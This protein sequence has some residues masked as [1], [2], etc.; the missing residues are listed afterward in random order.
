MRA[1]KQDNRVRPSSKECLGV[2]VEAS[3]IGLQKR[4]GSAHERWD[5]AG[6]RLAKIL[7]FPLQI[8]VVDASLIIFKTWRHFQLVRLILQLAS[9]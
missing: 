6:W 9:R 4:H 2:E 8:T 3:S 5:I 1:I 7:F